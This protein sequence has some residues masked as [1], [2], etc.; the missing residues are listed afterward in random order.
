MEKKKKLKDVE[1]WP[2]KRL[3]KRASGACLC[4]HTGFLYIYT[5]F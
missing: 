5:Y 2:H 3:D 1:K 4:D